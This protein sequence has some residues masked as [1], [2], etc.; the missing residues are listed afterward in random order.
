MGELQV[1]NVDD[2]VDSAEVRNVISVTG[3]CNPA[4][5]RVGLIRKMRN[6]LNSVWIKCPL[7][8]AIK[9]AGEGRICMGWTSARVRLLEAR[10]VQCF[11]C[12]RF[13]HVRNTCKFPEDRTGNCFRCGSGQHMVRDCVAPPQCAICAQYGR[14]ADHRLGSLPICNELGPNDPVGISEHPTVQNMET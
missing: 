6:G 5:V 12:W 9:V 4:D 7:A 14:R 3:D 2:T 1:W 10:P 8:A 13:G 11:K